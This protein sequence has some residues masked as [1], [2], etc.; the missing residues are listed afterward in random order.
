MN[1]YPIRTRFCKEIVAE[2]M[3][4]TKQ[5]GKVLI[6]LGG[7]PSM[8]SKPEI[9]T[10]WSS[11]GYTC[12][13]P[14][15]RG[16]W[17][18][19]GAFL[20]QSPHIDILDIVDEITNKKFVGVCDG[21]NEKMIP[22]QVKNIFII[23]GSFGGTG[24]V[25]ASQHKKVK[26]VVALAPVID[27]SIDGD[28]EPFDFFYR[29]TRYS[30]GDAYRGTELGWKKIKANKIYAPV[31]VGDTLPGEKIL[32]LHAADDTVVPIDPVYSFLRDSNASFIEYKK[33]GHL[34]LD[35]SRKAKY[36]KEIAHF[37]AAR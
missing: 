7:M 26:K 34:G 13:L 25:L 30:F 2:V 24:A 15:Y 17:E 33:G 22:I 31:R 35:D 14:R 6:L 29:F 28:A 9:M 36:Y 12:I 37:L 27:W 1:T 8:P 5:T 20:K 23:G 18:S 4:P 3:L 10:F 19:G 21:Y 32:I 11:K 16:T